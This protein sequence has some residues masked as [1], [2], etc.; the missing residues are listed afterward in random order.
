MFQR[1]AMPHGAG[2]ARV[3]WVCL[4]SLVLALT[5]LF[6]LPISAATDETAQ[7]EPSL[8]TT[9]LRPELA[10]SAPAVDNLP[11]GEPQQDGPVL[12]VSPAASDSQ[13]STTTNPDATPSAGQ[14]LPFKTR[15]SGRNGFPLKLAAAGLIVIPL[16]NALARA[17][18]RIPPEHPAD[19]LT[20]TVNSLGSP[21]FLLPLIGGMYFTGSKDD[22][23]TAK[24]ALSALV[25][26]AIMT[27]GMKALAGRARPVVSDEGEFAG[28]GTRK[29]Y[30]SFPS[31][32]TAS[33]FAVATVLAKRHPKQK[34]LY[35]GLATA[36]GIARVRKSAHFPSDVLVGAAVGI[37]A[38][39][40]VLRNG[41]RIFSIKL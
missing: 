33:A 30:T 24:M 6:S 3:R 10:A 4:P 41:P 36:V 35:Y 34:W 18:P 39:D 19:G 27:G 26:A 11:A 1:V 38:G 15:R 14:S 17:V 5:L 29:G 28:P 12:V 2:T 9:D 32:H 13:L 8:G 25:N 40:D 37:S 22:K 7:P 23:D 16:D 31:G 21:G 20:K